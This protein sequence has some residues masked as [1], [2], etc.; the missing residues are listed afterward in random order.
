MGQGLFAEDYPKVEISNK[1]I[2]AVVMLPD[3]VHGSYRA[4]RFDWSGVISSLQYGGHQFVSRWY[5]HQDPLVHDSI[6]GPAEEFIT[7]LGYDE[8]NSRGTF[9]RIGVGTLRKPD[10]KSFRRFSTYDV[11]DP[12]KWTVRKSAN[13]LVFIQKLKSD[14]GYGYVYRKTL[15]LVKGKPE[16]VI[17]HSLKN[18]GSKLLA[19]DEY[20]HNFFV[21]DHEVVGPSI[22]VHFPFVPKPLQTLKHGA[23]VRGQSIRYARDLKKG[24]V[25]FSEIRGFGDRIDS[26]NIRIE[27]HKA[28]VGV[29]ISGSRPLAKLLFWSIR[30]VACPEPYIRLH[31]EPGARARWKLTYV[32]YKIAP[33]SSE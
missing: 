9:V 3:P 25:V 15:R 28:G 6:T 22:S 26:Y 5:E 33:P 21:I 1:T 14:D 18:T 32:F 2:Q 30:T 20:C 12:G 27:N 8:A 23:E 7:S 19:T 31:I 13:K 4:T 16:L 17:E 24:E 29:R 10:E 11:V